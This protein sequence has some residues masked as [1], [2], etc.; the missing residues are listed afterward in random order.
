[1]NV[2]E[3]MENMEH[4]QL[5]FFNDNKTGLKGIIGIHNSVLGPALGGTRLW[6]YASEQEAINDVLRLSRGMSFKSSISGIHLG[7][8]KAVI[9][10]NPKAKKDEAYWRSYGKFV[11]NLGG[12]YITAEDVGTNTQF[13]EYIALETDHVAGK[14]DYLGGGGDPSPVT[15]YGVYLGMK[16]AQKQLSG[17]ESLRGKKVLVQGAG[18]VGQYLIDHLAKEKA[19]ISIAD[20]N[21]VNL[22]MVS[23]KYKVT[24]VAPTDVYQADMD[25]YAPCALGASLN[26]A[27]IPQL[28]CGIIAGAANNQLAEELVHGNLLRDKGII[29]APDFLINAGGVIN[30][31][32][33]TIGYNR[34]RALAATEKIYDQTLAV[35]NHAAKE[36]K[37]AQEVA[38]EIAIER[39]E[40][41]GKTRQRR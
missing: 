2:F 14:P 20:I 1:M 24:V 35:L 18:H 37:N 26:D 19:I 7:G 41:I 12:K 34:P 32:I 27:T 38:L 33:E 6:H 22:K 15:A 21:E 17:S 11:D 40:N 30:C 4:E 25:I 3:K 31:Y 16:A 8:G 9:I 13:I 29:Y 5:M 28:K 36:N 10:D 23:D 39:I